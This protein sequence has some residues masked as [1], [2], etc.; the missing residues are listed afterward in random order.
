MTNSSKQKA[1]DNKCVRLQY[2]NKS[3]V[4]KKIFTNSERKKIN[5]TKG[6]TVK[7]RNS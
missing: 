4:F 7:I 3:Y 5:I 2:L 6:K 1:I